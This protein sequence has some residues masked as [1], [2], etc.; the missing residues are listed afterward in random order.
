MKRFF[1]SFELSPNYFDFFLSKLV[2]LNIYFVFV[3]HVSK[4]FKC[5]GCCLFIKLLRFHIP[6]YVQRIKKNNNTEN[7]KMLLR[8]SFP[9]QSNIYGGWLHST[10]HFHQQQKKN[11]FKIQGYAY[12]ILDFTKQRATTQSFLCYFLLLLVSVFFFLSVMKYKRYK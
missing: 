11:K 9:S 3:F 12:C 7:I 6:R 5:S 1:S 2:T 10:L 8:Q 4:A